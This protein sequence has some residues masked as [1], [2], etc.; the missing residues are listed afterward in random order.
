M[1]D[2]TALQSAS[3]GDVIATDDIGGVKFQRVKLIHGADGTNDGDVATGNPLPVTGTVTVAAVLGVVPGTA[4]TR[5]GKEVGSAAGATDTGV[6]MLFIRDD[7]LSTLS[8]AEGDYVPARVDSSGAVWV[9]ARAGLAQRTDDSIFSPGSGE[10]IM[11][12]FEADETATDSVDEGDAGAARMTLDRKVIINPQPHTAGGLDTFMASGS[13][14]STAL[15]NSAQAIKASAGQIYGWYLYNTNSAAAAY[16]HI[17][18]A[19]A[20]AVNVGTTN[21]KWTWS[22]PAGAAANQMS[23]MGI[24]CPSAGFSIAATSTASGSAAPAVAIDAVIWYM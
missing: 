23:T 17:Y 18:S 22:L 20:G 15:T 5:L 10:I 14:G 19:S 9:V 7:A 2:N 6:A 24:N 12:G 4:A 1:A 21:P 11:V 8:D 13:D 16:V 3:G